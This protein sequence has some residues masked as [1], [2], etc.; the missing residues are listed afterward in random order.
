MR[1]APV[2]LRQRSEHVPA[3]LRSACGR[4]IPLHV[5]RWFAEPTP[6]ELV[7]LAAATG[8]VL[9]IGCGPGRHVLAL[10]AIGI[11]A[12][13]VDNAPSAVEAARRRG[14]PAILGSIFDTI[15]SEGRWRTAV[16]FDGNVGIGGDPRRLL[17]RVHEVLAPAGRVLV[18]VEPPG[19][20]TGTLRVRAEVG[21]ET[22]STWFAWALVGADEIP[23]IGEAASFATTDL[24]AVGG[25]WFARLEAR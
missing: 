24:R 8:P 10:N 7:A 14:A 1:G 23:A 25:R 15:P 12:V 17:R 11:A 5:D 6:E 22:T 9:D 2:A 4:E 13:G 20:G 18:E 3:R 21:D 16:L 19:Q